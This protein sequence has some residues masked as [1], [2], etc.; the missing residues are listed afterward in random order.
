MQLRASVLSLYT[1][2]TPQTLNMKDTAII[3]AF[4]HSFRL[5]NTA[6]GKGVVTHDM[7]KELQSGKILVAGLD[8]LEYEKSSFE[9]LFNDDQMPEAFN[10]LIHAE[11]VLLSPHVAGWTKESKEKLAQTIVNKIKIHFH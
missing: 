3:Q 4:K 2:E 10:Y 5:I 7:M 9:N 1:P 11:N 8:V 6:R